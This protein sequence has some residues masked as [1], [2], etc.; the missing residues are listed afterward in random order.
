[1]L[2]EAIVQIKRIGNGAFIAKSDIESAFRLL[3]V[4]KE[5]Y[6]LLG[7][8]WKGKYFFEKTLPMGCSSSCRLFETFSS[9]LEFLVRHQSGSARVLHVLDDFLFIGS[10][11]ADC[12][13]LLDTFIAIFQET[14]VPIAKDKTFG[15]LQCLTFLGI[16]LNC[17]QQEARLP[18]D[19]LAKCREMLG[20][21]LHRKKVTLKE[22]LS[23]LGFLNFCC[24]VVIPGR[25]FTRR[26]IHK[27]KG[28]RELHH[29][30]KLSKECKL[31]MQMWLEFLD[32][33]NGRDLSI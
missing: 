24:N 21:F 17:I 26:L 30:I 25:A 27:T 1:M 22:M 6:H 13:H 10:T 5:D 19:K 3:P 4:K 12:Q 23:L 29:R 15:P 20:A 33:F 32:S 14:G 2:D 8:Q 7:F 9:A 16:E 18:D 28:I 11:A 31:D